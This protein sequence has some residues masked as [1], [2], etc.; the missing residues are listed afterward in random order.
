MAPI[1]STKNLTNLLGDVRRTNNFIMTI[2][3]VTD[4]SDLE[5]VMQ[6]AWLPKLSINVLELRHGNDA[7]KFAGTASWE[8]G[9]CTIIDTLSKDELDTLLEWVNLVYKWQEG[10]IGLASEYKKSGLIT[11]YASNGEYV[12]EWKVEG[13]WPSDIDLGQLN[14]AQA[15]LKEISFTIQ[16]DPSRSFAPTYRNYNE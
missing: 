11:E 4:S 7:L 5:L 15:E 14:A 12:R 3:G 9:Q 1:S 6:N 8:G 10:S 16:I 13:L 2:E